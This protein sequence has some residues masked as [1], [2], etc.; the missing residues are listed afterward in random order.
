MKICG[1]ILCAALVFT[2]LSSDARSHEYAEPKHGGAVD[3]VNDLEFE[4]TQEGEDAIL[5]VDDSETPYRMQNV[6]GTLTITNGADETKAELVQA[7]HDKLVARG[8][9]LAK[10]S[11]AVAV[12]AFQA[13]GT[14]IA[15]FFID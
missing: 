5:Y 8:V 10:G 9:K 11:K 13:H 2:V 6:R 7:A 1:K 14:L 3:Q 15:R 12:I 4:L